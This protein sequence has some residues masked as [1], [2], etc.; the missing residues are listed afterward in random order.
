MFL[1]P[2]GVQIGMEY[3]APPVCETPN[4]PAVRPTAAPAV[5]ES[6]VRQVTT[7]AATIADFDIVVF[8]IGISIARNTLCRVDRLSRWRSRC[9]F[10]QRMNEHHER[11]PQAPESPRLS[12]NC[13]V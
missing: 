9:L 3:V 2:G 1:T 5:V 6:S 8:L 10:A 7:R 12:V 4:D 13:P 11:Q